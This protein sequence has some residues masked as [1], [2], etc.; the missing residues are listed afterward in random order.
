ME[1]KN[2]AQQIM[3]ISLV[4]KI[5]DFSQFIFSKENY[6]KPIECMKGPIRLNQT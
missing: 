3:C 6:L 4:P 2:I 1:Y 5:S